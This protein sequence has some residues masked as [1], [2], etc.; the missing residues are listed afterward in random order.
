MEYTG[1]KDVTLEAI[2]EASDKFGDSYF[3]NEEKYHSLDEICDLIDELM[4]DEE[5]DC[6]AL[7]VGVDTTT[8][9]L[10]FTMVY[11]EIIL[12]HGRT[13]KFFTLAK[14]VD[15][16]RFSKAKPDGLCIE[17]GVSG[18]WLRGYTYE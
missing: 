11:D 4:C 14:L 18:L 5:L 7:T 12:Q 13:H 1:C 2:E 9:E 16:I 8:K 6:H 3:L 15:A 17:L 10:I